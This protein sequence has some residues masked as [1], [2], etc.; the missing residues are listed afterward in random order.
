MILSAVLC[1]AFGAIGLGSKT[2]F[3]DLVGSFIILTTTSY[4]CAIA[5]H[6]LTGRKNVPP[7]PFWMGKAGFFVQ[8]MAVIM[9]IFFNIMFC[10]RKFPCSFTI[11]K[12]RANCISSIC[13]AC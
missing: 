5:P 3:A 11:L 6:L 12:L 2:A 13:N 1:V 7:G 9:I 4:A 8:G 10:F